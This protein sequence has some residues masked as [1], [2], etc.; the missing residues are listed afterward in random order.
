MAKETKLRETGATGTLV[1]QITAALREA[2]RHGEF[3]AGQRLIVADLSEQFGVSFG[4]IREAIRRL[5]GEGYLDFTPHK[6]ATVR[7]F[8]E[9]ELREVFQVREAIESFAARLAAENIHH[10]DYAQRLTA[11]HKDLHDHMLGGDAQKSSDVRQLFHDLLYEVA[12]NPYLKEAG[13]RFTYPLHRVRFNEM[14]GRVRTEDSLREHDDI[15]RAV[16]A[17][18]GARAE[19]MMRI[20]LRNR[21]TAFCELL[22]EINQT[23]SDVA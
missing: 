4:P 11:C 2:V 18:D 14:A 22:D 10:G 16:L 6:G 8:G 5:A 15:I 12:G 21:A 9:K 19:R 3:K 17:G 23:E 13:Q 1:E 7:G 20:H